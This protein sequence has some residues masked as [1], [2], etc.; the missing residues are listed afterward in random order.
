[1]DSEAEKKL[2]ELQHQQELLKE[3]MEG[4][5]EAMKTDNESTVAKNDTGRV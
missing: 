2:T 5:M 4:N 3:R 1:M